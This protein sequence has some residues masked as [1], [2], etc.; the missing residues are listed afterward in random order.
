M[1]HLRETAEGYLQH[2][3]Q[4]VLRLS[5]A[6]LNFVYPPACLLCGREIP[7]ADADFCDLCL[8]QL[9]PPT[10]AECPRCGAPVGPFANLDKGCG[11]CRREKFA[12]DRLI[13]LGIYDGQM[14]MAC[15]R[16]KAAGGGSLARG[17]AT[18]LVN[19]KRFA[20]EE[21]RPDLVLPVPEH[22]TRRFLHTHYAAEELARHVAR[23]LRVG[24]SRSIL[25]KSRRTPKQATSPTPVRR[26]Q[27]Q[28]S[29][30]VRL[31][32]R[33]A[34][35]RILLVDDILT[36]GSTASAAARSLK[37]AGAS[38]VIVAVVAVSPLRR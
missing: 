28:G 3:S 25:M 36:T 23:Q 7:P 5:D 29:F 21:C 35:K 13:R 1:S 24:V 20:F 6:A 12:F 19:R 9:C 30:A 2:V 22:W 33:V 32:Q 34:G 11:Q 8:A 18:L 16:T 31:A 14:R 10:H 27:Q 37:Q 26:Q 4:S 38:Q 15:L 17:L